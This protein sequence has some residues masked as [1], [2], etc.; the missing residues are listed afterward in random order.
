MSVMIMLT[1]KIM[2]EIVERQ[3]NWPQ[4]QV[5]NASQRLNPVSKV[6]YSM[7][8]LARHE[9]QQPKLHTL[10][11]NSSKVCATCH[12]SCR[13]TGLLTR[14]A[15]FFDTHHD[16]TSNMQHMQAKVSA[17]LQQCNMQTNICNVAAASMQ[18]N[19]ATACM[20]EAML[21]SSLPSA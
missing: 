9:A 21:T 16:T 11:R 1:M 6:T 15:S 19:V 5:S 8:N 20:H 2:V 17:K 3:T 10:F 7:D 4:V 18:H 13:H 14:H 12:S